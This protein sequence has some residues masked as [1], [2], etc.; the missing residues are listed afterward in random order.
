[1]HPHH[2]HHEEAA[3]Y[4]DARALGLVRS[5]DLFMYVLYSNDQVFVRD[6]VSQVAREVAREQACPELDALLESNSPQLYRCL[7]FLL[8]DFHSKFRFWALEE[9][10]LGLQPLCVY[11]AARFLRV[12]NSTLVHRFLVDETIRLDEFE[13]ELKQEYLRS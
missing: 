3:Q 7:F 9:A 13:R 5:M 1:M 11:K 6:M 2:H 10:Q 4:A 8:L 12:L